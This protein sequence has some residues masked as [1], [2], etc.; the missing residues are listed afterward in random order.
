MKNNDEKRTSIAFFLSK[1]DKELI[2]EI[3][4]NNI[5]INSK[6]HLVEIAL[7]EFL[8]KYKEEKITIN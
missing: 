6:S 1:E 7:H 2:N 8:K 5:Y 3:V 4:E